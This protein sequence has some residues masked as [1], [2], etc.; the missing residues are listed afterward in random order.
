MSPLFRPFYAIGHGIGNAF[1]AVGTTAKGLL[2]LD[3]KKAA[4]GAT[5][6]VHGGLDVGRGLIDLTPAGLAG[7]TLLKGGT[8]RLVRLAQLPVRTMVDNPITK[9]RGTTLKD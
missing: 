2:T 8:D 7:N 3:L 1:K 9:T 5:S 6:F 4:H